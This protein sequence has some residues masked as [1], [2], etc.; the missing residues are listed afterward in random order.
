MKLTQFLHRLLHSPSAAGSTKL[1]IGGGSHGFCFVHSKLILG[2][3]KRQ[4]IPYGIALE[5]DTKSHTNYTALR[6]GRVL[7][8]R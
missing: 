1:G 3:V 4:M 8:C 5:E 2:Y 6:D 7:S